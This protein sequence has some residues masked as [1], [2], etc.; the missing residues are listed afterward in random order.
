ME[1]IQEIR[2]LDPDIRYVERQLFLK[3]GARKTPLVIGPDVGGRKRVKERRKKKIAPLASYSGKWSSPRRDRYIWLGIGTFGG[4]EG[5]KH[6]GLIF[7][8]SR[9]EP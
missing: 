2:N 8:L 5:C 7:K 4:D 1:E 9:A 6:P 3:P